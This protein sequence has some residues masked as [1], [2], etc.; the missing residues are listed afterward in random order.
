M[1]F[2]SLE[3]QDLVGTET[4]EDLVGTKT[5]RKIVLLGLQDLQF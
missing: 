4:F 5:S 1:G 2:G 3:F